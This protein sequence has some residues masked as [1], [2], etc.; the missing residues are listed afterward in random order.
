MSSLGT[1][2][3]Y[4]AH[5]F[6]WSLSI[7]SFGTVLGRCHL[8]IF[9]RNSFSVAKGISQ[10]GFLSLKKRYQSGGLRFGETKTKDRPGGGLVPKRIFRKVQHN[11]LEHF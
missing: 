4:W 11:I 9:I 6:S 1:H 3:Y 8:V 5:T 10:T 7:F 2:M